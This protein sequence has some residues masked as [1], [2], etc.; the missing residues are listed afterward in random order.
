MAD[1]RIPR[2]RDNDYTAEMMAARRDFARARTGV[3]LDHVGRTTIGPDRLP[4]NIENAIGA[5]QVPIGLAGPLTVHGEHVGPGEDVYVPMA[6]TEGTLVASYNRG[7][8]LLRE[9]GGAR[10][11]IVERYM[12]R[13]PVFHFDGARDARDFG[14][15]LDDNFDGVKRAADATTSVGRLSHVERYSVGAMLYTRMNFTT[16]DAAGQNMSGKAANAACQWIADHYQ[17]ALKGYTLSGAIDTDKKHSQLNT[18]HSRGA[19]VVAEVVLAPDKTEALMRATTTQL[20][21]VRNVSHTGGMLAG[22]SSNGLHAANGLAA[23]FIATG[24]D[25]ANVAESQASISFV[26]L[27]DDGSLYWSLTLPSLIMATHGGGTGLPTQ[28]E[29]L[30]LMGCVGTG[31]V[32]RLLEITAATVLAGELSLSSA[33]VAG[34]W[35]SSHDELGRNR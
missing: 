26:D 34:D 22:T 7:M 11:T 25:A 19:R 8:R 21:R 18:I 3:A 23:L 10:V 16:G 30:A 15:W 1:P 20:F 24:Q 14:V 29:C 4:G 32:G 28:A 31:K 2:N 17:G 12:Q 33:I 35:V 27:R 13:A 6:T 9:C 5:A